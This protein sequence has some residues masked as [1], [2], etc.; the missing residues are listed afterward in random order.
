MKRE[1]GFSIATAPES[2]RSEAGLPAFHTSSLNAVPTNKEKQAQFPSQPH[3]LS[4]EPFRNIPKLS[5]EV[6]KPE[7]LWHLSFTEAHG[8]YRGEG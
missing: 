7:N 3:L 6:K 5:I 2:W 4:S 8:V 1:L